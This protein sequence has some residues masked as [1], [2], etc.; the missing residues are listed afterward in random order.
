MNAPIKR[1]KSESVKALA[2]FMHTMFSA[3][4]RGIGRLLKVGDVAVLKW[5]RN[6]AKSLER[7]KIP[8][9]GEGAIAALDEMW[10]FVNGKPNKVWIWKAY[11]LKAG[12]T[13][14]WKLGKRDAA[15]LK[16]FLD[17]IGIEGRDFVT[18]D[19]EAY[20][21]LIPEAQ[22]STGKHLTYP[23][24]QDN[25]NTRHYV[26]RFRRRSKITSRSLEMVDLSLPLLYHFQHGNL[27]PAL[28]SLVHQLVG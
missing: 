17:E 15:T 12:K 18:D 11:D 22:L 6:F 1:G 20:H 4:L 8:P 21:K 2:I 14:A 25:S 5:V 24:E 26:G 7:P 23:I 13:F 10:H 19:C 3:S 9:A 16:E 27:F 28:Q